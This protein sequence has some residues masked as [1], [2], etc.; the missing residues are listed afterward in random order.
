MLKLLGTALFC[1]SCFF[2]HVVLVPACHQQRQPTAL[3]GTQS[4]AITLTVDDIYGRTAN[5]HRR[6][7]TVPIPCL[8]I[9]DIAGA[10]QSGGSGRAHTN[11][12]CLLVCVCVCVCLHSGPRG[13]AKT[14]QSVKDNSKLVSQSVSQGQFNTSQPKKLQHGSLTSR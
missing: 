9:H 6:G 5:T 11:S 10:Q 14:G 3:K 8:C 12:R 13:P 4:R 7:S 2:L 1:L